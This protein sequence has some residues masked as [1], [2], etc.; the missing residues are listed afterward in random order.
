M[1]HYGPPA[2]PLKPLSEF[3]GLLQEIFPPLILQDQDCFAGE[4]GAEELLALLPA[5]AQIEPLRK[6]WSAN[7]DKTSEE[8]WDDIRNQVKILGKTTAPGVSPPPHQR[9]GV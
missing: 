2:I 5:S 9:Q 4:A 6:K 1:D 8:K 7:P 3:I